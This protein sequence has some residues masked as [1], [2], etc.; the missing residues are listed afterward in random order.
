MRNITHGMAMLAV[1]RQWTRVMR[2]PVRA[3]D[4]LMGA[5]S[6]MIL[7]AALAPFERTGC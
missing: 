7:R 1:G 4:I 3:D 5:S 2:H 6:H